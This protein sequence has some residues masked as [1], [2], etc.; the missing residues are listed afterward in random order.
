MS[1]TLV[2]VTDVLGHEG[3]EPLNSRIHDLAQAGKVELLHVAEED[4]A[5][6]RLRLATDRGTDCAIMLPRGTALY[7]GAVVD[8][9]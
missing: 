7:D 1:T 2:Q 4:L 5:R 9:A 6:S 3:D 8:S